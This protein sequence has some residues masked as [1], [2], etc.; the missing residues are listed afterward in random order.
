MLTNYNVNEIQAFNDNYIWAITH[1]LS[2]SCVIVDPGCSDEVIDYLN[3]RN[4]TLEA[5]LITHHHNDHIGGVKKLQQLFPNVI[6]YGPA[7]EAQNVVSVPLQE[8][9]TVVIEKLG[10]S[11]SVLD[12]P[13]HTLGHIV[14]FDNE[15]LFSGDTLFAGGCGRMFEGTPDMFSSSLNK[16]SKLSPATKVY[17]AHEYTLNNLSFAKAVEPN[18]TELDKRITLCERQRDK[19]RPTVP[20]TI[21]QELSTNPFLR[22]THTD[23]VHSLNV[24]FSLSLANNSVENFQWLRHWKDT[25]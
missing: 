5:I 22:L 12:V 19:N 11:L 21:E 9:D 24:E 20:S 7:K 23:V 2:S 6:V 16:L 25:F 17:C 13:G 18:S 10:L 8:D 3:Q 15:S 14:Y 1:D 4:L